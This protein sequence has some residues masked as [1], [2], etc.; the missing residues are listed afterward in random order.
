MFGTPPSSSSKEINAPKYPG[1]VGS[2]SFINT[3]QFLHISFTKHEVKHVHILLESLHLA[4]FGN[5]DGI[6]LNA[7]SERYLRRGFLIFGGELL[8]T[9]Q[10][11]RV[12]VL[13]SS[14]HHFAGVKKEKQKQKEKKKEE[15]K[16]LYDRV[17]E[18]RDRTKPFRVGRTTSERC[19]SRDSNPMLLN[20]LHQRLSLKVRMCLNLVHRRLDR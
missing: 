1:Q 8:H 3:L 9:T 5:H 18:S 19:M 14:R 11:C 12:K 2:C 4:R 7:P 10:C 6:A 17:V 13:P 15:E 20:E 16:N